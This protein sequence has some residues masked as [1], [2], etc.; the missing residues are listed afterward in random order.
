MLPAHARQC[1]GGATPDPDSIETAIAAV[2]GQL[3]ASRLLQGE[4]LLRTAGVWGERSA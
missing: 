1:A 3:D 2:A 4:M